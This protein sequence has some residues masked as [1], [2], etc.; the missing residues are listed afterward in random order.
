MRFF[1]IIAT[2]F[3]LI[4]CA[5]NEERQ[6]YAEQV[7]DRPI[8]TTTEGRV[9]ECNWIRSE[10]ARQQSLAQYGTSM[11]TSPMMAMAYQAATRN[12][13]A[14]LESRASNVECQ[15]AFS[16]VLQSPTSSDAQHS[17][18]KNNLDFDQCFSRCKKLTDRTKD[19]CFDACK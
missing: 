14:A 16:S 12:N 6:S 9:Q 19:Q 3:F 10:I 15:A 1:I 2:I 18:A 17:G 8:P 4:G 13:I 11:A 7:L 5:T